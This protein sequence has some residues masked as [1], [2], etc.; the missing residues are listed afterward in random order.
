VTTV[1]AELRQP[2]V[3]FEQV[4]LPG[5]CT[6]GGIAEVVGNYPSAGGGGE[7]GRGKAD[8]RVAVRHDYRWL[9]TDAGRR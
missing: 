9:R 5:L 1:V 4:Y 6:A 8:R 7:R 3:G 2:G